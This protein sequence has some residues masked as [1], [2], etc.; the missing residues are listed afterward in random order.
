VL[1]ERR[2]TWQPRPAHAT[3]GYVKLY[4]DH[5]M[6]ADKGADFDFLVGGSG[7]APILKGNH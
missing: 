5:V 2:A 4:L 1:A 7:G 6:G 3:R